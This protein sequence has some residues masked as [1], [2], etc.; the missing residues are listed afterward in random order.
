MLRRSDTAEPTAE[1]EAE[2]ELMARGR[3]ALDRYAAVPRLT[4]RS[5]LRP[6][7]L[8]AAEAGQLAAVDP[9]LAPVAE[10]LEATVADRKLCYWGRRAVGQP[11]SDALLAA[12]SMELVHAAAVVHDELIDDSVL[13]HGR[14]TA[15]IVLR[16]AV[17][18]RP[19]AAAARSPAMPAGDL[20]TALAG[21]PFATSGL[22][23]AHLARPG[24]C[25]Q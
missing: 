3:P 7:W 12:A 13:R 20:P 1:A 10:Q 11:D 2:H 23:A 16:G 4:W 24:P 17:L 21:Q 14:P 19:A 22:P 25:G 15:H 9:L 6:P 8:V 18:C 5:S